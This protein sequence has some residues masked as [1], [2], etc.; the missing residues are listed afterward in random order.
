MPARKLRPLWKCPE[1]GHK[2]VTK[3][4]SHSC[5]RHR[6]ADHFVGVDPVIHRT[7]NRWRAVA[8]ANGPVT[9]YAQK[10]RII[11]MV[12][13]RFGGAS[14]R[15]TWLDARL[16]LKRKPSHPLMHR[17]HDYGSIGYDFHVKLTHP[18]QVDARLEALMR[19]AYAIGKQEHL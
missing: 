13:V 7:F 14:V 18:S 8:E 3:N 1:C 4:L 5:G 6:L 11:F 2:F 17:L 19:E 12:R 16:W 9:V 15:K 10:T